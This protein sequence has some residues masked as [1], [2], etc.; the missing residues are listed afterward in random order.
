MLFT[1]KSIQTFTCLVIVCYWIKYKD[2]V[3]FSICYSGELFI[4]SLLPIL[5]ILKPT[6]FVL[7]RTLNK[8][9]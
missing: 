6:V 1:R 4:V 8:D 9:V 5:T 7:G 3:H 2:M